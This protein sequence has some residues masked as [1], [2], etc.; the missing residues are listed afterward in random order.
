MKYFIYCRKSQEAEDRQVMSLESQNDEIERLLEHRPDIT[1]VERFEEAYSAK[2][3]GR[4]LFDQMIGRIEQGEAEGII[5]WHPDRLARNSMDGGKIIHLLDQ[6][7]LKDLQFCNFTFEN[8]SQGKFMLTIVFG[9]SKYY[10]DELSTNVK[11]G[12]R[13]KLKNGWL[14][15]RAP[16]GYRNCPETGTIIPHEPHFSTLR[17]IFDLVLAD[18]HSVAAISRIVTKDWGYRTPQ[19]KTR[20][21]KA[22]SRSALYRLVTNPFYAGYVSWNGQLHAGQHPPIITKAEHARVLELVRKPEK[23]RSK[24]LEFKYGGVFRCGSCGRAVTAERKRKPSGRT[25]TYYH[26]T[27]VHQSPKCTQPSIEERVLDQ[28]VDAFVKAISLP[29][30]SFDQFAKMLAG[31]QADSK[32]HA[33][34]EQANWQA[35]V[36]ALDTQLHNLTDLRIRGLIDDADFTD[37]KRQLTIERD[38]ANENAQ[39]AEEEKNMF[40]PVLLLGKLCSRATSWWSEAKPETKRALLQIL[41]SN[42]RLQDKKALLDPIKPFALMLDMIG[43]PVVRADRDFVRTDEVDGEHQGTRK[44]LSGLCQQTELQERTDQL[45]SLVAATNGKECSNQQ[46][47]AGTR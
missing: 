26:C 9:Q 5:A 46:N 32:S 8:S 35:Q 43:N 40:E 17:R 4:P 24:R 22:L 20:G 23:E 44:V 19:W 10:V 16:I 41:C 39:H 42:P 36:K 25:Y 11:R 45:R 13:T 34:Q 31:W 21:G 7:L 14:P 30:N 27:R 18:R 1:I 6:G 15:N 29:K 37:R 38:R 2:Q 12:Q 33:M 28:Q 47:V 3:P